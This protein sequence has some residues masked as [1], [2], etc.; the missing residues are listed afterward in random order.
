MTGSG[1]LLNNQCPDIIS[2]FG[3]SITG[4]IEGKE[5]LY[6]TKGH[7]G[8]IWSLAVSENSHFIIASGNTRTKDCHIDTIYLKESVLKWGLDTLVAYC[9]KMQPVASSSVGPFH[10]R[11]VLFSS[12]KEI[13]FDC[14]DTNTYSGP[15]SI[16]FNNQL[17]ELKY[18]MYWFATPIEIQKKLPTPHKH[19]I[20]DRHVSPAPCVRREKQH[21]SRPER[22]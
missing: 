19:I 12:Q 1:S 15:D 11:L 3:D 20:Q 5:F 17:N 8:H 7:H 9:Q 2:K 6:Y 10:E 4:I 16:T 14:T 18:L 13:I 22:R 21:S